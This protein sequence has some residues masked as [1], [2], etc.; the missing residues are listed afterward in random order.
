MLVAFFKGGFQQEG[1]ENWFQTKKDA[2]PGMISNQI[3]LLKMEFI[4]PI[5]YGL[6]Y[7][8]APTGGAK[9][10]RKESSLTLCCNK[11]FVILYIY[12]GHMQKF[13]QDFRTSKI[14]ELIFCITLTSKKIYNSLVFEDT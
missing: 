6:S 8:L 1:N 13:E 14:C 10:S 9:I 7:S 3:M 2:T 11:A 12:R 4:N 5:S